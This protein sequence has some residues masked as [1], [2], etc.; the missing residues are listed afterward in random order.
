MI[1]GDDCHYVSLIS[2]FEANGAKVIP[3]FSGGLDFSLP[4][5]RYFFHRNTSNANVDVFV[6][7]TG[8]ALVGGPAK[9]D[10]PKAIAVLKKLDRPYLCAL[11]LVFQ[12]TEEW[13]ESELGLHPVQVALQVSLP[14][15]D[16][17]IEPVILLE[18][19]VLRVDPFQCRTELPHLQQEP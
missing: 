15:L 5:E 8:F 13:R 18:E 10:H 6:S 2:E 16:G 17:A 19:M 9:Q 12:T 3:V 11:P 4:V 14:E 7:L 1:T